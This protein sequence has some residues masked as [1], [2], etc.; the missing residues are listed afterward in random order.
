MSVSAKL[1]LDR[2]QGQLVVSC[3][4]AAGTPLEP[5]QHIVAL[6]RSAVLGGAKAVRIEGVA[7]VRAVRAAIEVPI[8]G[9]TK[10]QHPGYEAFITT[11]N[12]EV[13]QLVEA[14][15]DIIAFD[16]TDRA[17]PVPVRDVVAAILAHDRLAM[18]DISTLAEA[19]H[20]IDAGA[21]VAGTTLAGYT[22]YSADMA[23]P[24][25]PLM[26]ALAQAG[27]P[28]VAEGRIWEPAEAAR[29]IALG[30]TFVVVGS[31]ITRPDDITRRYADAVAAAAQPR[32]G[33]TA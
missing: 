26:A 29:A 14:G 24:D 9:I 33:E 27:L 11:T 4:A 25:F 17:R 7:N 1:L 3:Q 13:D 19:R 18:A 16:A 31:A 6:A 2:L 5:T 32:F 22:T 23:G 8:I 30:A 28:F 12:G 20:A 15:A 21:H 10:A